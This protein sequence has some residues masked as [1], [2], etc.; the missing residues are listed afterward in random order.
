VTT[1]TGKVTHKQRLVAMPN[2][3]PT[4][5]NDRLTRIAEGTRCG[6]KSATTTAEMVDGQSGTIEL[7]T[8]VFVR[9]V[10]EKTDMASIW[11]GRDQKTGRKVD[12]EI[13][14]YHNPVRMDKISSGGYM[15]CHWHGRP[16]QTN[17]WQYGVS[18]LGSF[19]MEEIKGVLKHPLMVVKI[20]SPGDMAG[21]GKKPVQVLST[22]PDLH[23]EFL[24]LWTG[25]ELPSSWIILPDYGLNLNRNS[26][27]VMRWPQIDLG[28]QDLNDIQRP[29]SFQINSWK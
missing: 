13:Y 19:K 23:W 25:F 4:M 29:K 17:K 9:H 22:L 2:Q 10:D 5:S 21:P 3:C 16:G 20:T 6:D 27:C 8:R 26:F 15:Y 24:R 11:I 12:K 7:P 28:A 1:P 14:E 18:D